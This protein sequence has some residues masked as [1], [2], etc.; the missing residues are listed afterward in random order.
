M[1]KRSRE[2]GGSTQGLTVSAEVASACSGKHWSERGGER[3]LRRWEVEDDDVEA[4]GGVRRCTARRGGRGILG[5]ALGHLRASP[6]WRCPRWW[7]AAATEAFGGKNRGGGERS[8]ERSRRR[9]G[10]VAPSRC[11]GEEPGRQGGRRWPRRVAARVGHA[12]SP[13]GARRKAT[14]ERLVGW[15]ASWAGQ[16]GCTVGRSR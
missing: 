10:V 13:T 5:G 16:V 14:G 2:E 15:A 3:D 12:P 9:G 4:L 1:S 7:R 11:N 6:G 8:G